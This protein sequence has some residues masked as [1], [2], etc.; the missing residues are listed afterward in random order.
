MKGRIGIIAIGLGFS[1]VAF[2]NIDAERLR[3]LATRLRYMAYRL[4]EKAKDREMAE[5][6][7]VGA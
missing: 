6:E 3:F 5:A 1:L 2:L 4:D 7:K